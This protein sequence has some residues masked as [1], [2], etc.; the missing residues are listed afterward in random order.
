[1]G[2][3]EDLG[4]PLGT[5]SVPGKNMEKITLAAVERHL[6]NNAIIRQI[7]KVSQKESPV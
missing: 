6:K 1:M 5:I 2:V 3:R 7:N 4:R